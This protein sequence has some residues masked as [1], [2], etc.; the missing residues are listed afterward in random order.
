M[1]IRKLMKIIRIVTNGGTVI[2][3]KSTNESTSFDEITE[4]TDI[5]DII[6][7]R[8]CRFYIKDGDKPLYELEEI[9]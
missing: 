7:Y 8:Y 5:E 1:I 6:K 4:F 2:V 3:D 9:G